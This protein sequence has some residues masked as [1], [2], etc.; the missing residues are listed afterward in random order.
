MFSISIYAV[1][2]IMNVFVVV[3]AA[4]V[5]GIAVVVIVVS[6]VNVVVVASVVAAVSVADTM[7]GITRSSR[8]GR[9]VID[10]IAKTIMTTHRI[11][12]KILPF[13]ILL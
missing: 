6:S 3:S 11:I 2:G 1:C 9:R 13:M 7:A 12:T 8:L 5:I 4:V 10:T